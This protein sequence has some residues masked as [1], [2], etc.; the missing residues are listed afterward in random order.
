MNVK[1]QIETKNQRI[2]DNMDELLILLHISA[3]FIGLI[4]MF[5]FVYILVTRG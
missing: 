4:L 1:T 3:G 5:V 2:V